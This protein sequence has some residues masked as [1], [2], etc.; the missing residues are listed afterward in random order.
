MWGFSEYDSGAMRT[1][2]SPDQTS[3]LLR[4]VKHLRRLASMLFAYF[5]AGARV[6]R[7]YRKKEEDG[8]VVWVDEEMSP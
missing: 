6:R 5:T 1:I 4:D 2:D 3:T 7:L 8:D